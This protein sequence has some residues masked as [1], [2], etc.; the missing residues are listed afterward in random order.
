MH[1]KMT[2]STRNAQSIMKTPLK[3]MDAKKYNESLLNPQPII[4]T[5]SE[6]SVV[7]PNESLKVYG[8]SLIHI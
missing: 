7:G 2:L 4:E 6:Q 3:S 8:L 5:C 1:P